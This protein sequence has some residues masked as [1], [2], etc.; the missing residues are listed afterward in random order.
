LILGIL[1]LDLISLCQVFFDFYAM[2]LTTIYKPRWNLVNI[3]HGARDMPL[4][5][6]A[7]NG[8]LPISYGQ[9]I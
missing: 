3:L 5:T 8:G 1:A 4:L 2:F 9:I 7:G 6:F